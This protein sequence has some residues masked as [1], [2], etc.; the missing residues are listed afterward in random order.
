M[1]KKKTIIVDAQGKNIKGV[2]KDV[3]Q[4]R[5]ETEKLDKSRN[6]LNKTTDSYNRREKGAAQMGMNSTKSFSKMQQT[7]GDE[8]GGGAGGL[9]RAYALL[10][11][12]VF[13]LSA[14]FGILSRSAQVDT[15][16]ESMERL[17]VVT[18]NA[19]K[20]MARELQAAAS[21]GLDFA[22]AMRSTSLA[23]SA[24]FD[25]STI[26]ELG[27][28]AKNAAVSLGRP[29]ADSLDRIFRG[30]IKVE[31]ELLDEIGLFVRVKEASARYASSLGMAASELTEFQKRQAFATESVRQGQEKFEEFSD[32]DIDAFAL[33]AA[34]F[35]DLAHEA[36][37]FVNRGLGPII[38]LLAENKELLGAAF[39]AIAI[40]LL[41]K[42][43]PAMGLFTRSIADQ[44][45]T[46]T[47]A[48]TKYVNEIKTKAQLEKESLLESIALQ[49]QKTQKEIEGAQKARRLQD[50]ERGFKGG[51]KLTQAK[52]EIK[53][54]VSGQQRIN[55]LKQKQVALNASM[56]DSTRQAI[57]EEQAALEREIQM[58]IELLNIK[59]QQKQVSDTEIATGGKNKLAQLT[60]AKLARKEILAVG[61]ASVAATA[62]THGFWA[63]LKQINV[64]LGL[65][66]VAAKDAGIRL[67]IFARTLFAVRGAVVALTTAI[68]AL[69]TRIMG[70]LGWVLLLLPVITYFLKQLGFWS[71]EAKILGK[72][73]DEMNELIENFGEKMSH[74]ANVLRD[75]LSP[76]LKQQGAQLALSRTI[77][78]TTE[79]IM[80]QAQALEVYKNS[81]Q[82]IVL[83]WHDIRTDAGFGPEADKLRAEHEFFGGLIDTWETQTK[84]IQDIM[85][86]EGAMKN[87]VK[88]RKE[89]NVALREQIKAQKA[90]DDYTR[91]GERG[92]SIFTAVKAARGQGFKQMWIDANAAA[93]RYA[94]NVDR[95]EA[96][97]EKK[98]E[99]ARALGKKY[100]QD[101]VSLVRRLK[102]MLGIY[103]ELNDAATREAAGGENLLSIQ[104]GA[105]DALRE[106]ADQFLVKT[107]IDK[108]LATFAQATKNIMIDNDKIRVSEK[109]RAAF[110]KAIGEDNSAIFDLMSRQNQLAYEKT[111]EIENQA[112]REVAQM[113]ILQDQKEEYERQQKIMIQ[114]KTT[115]QSI[116]KIQKMMTKLI[117]EHSHFAAV[118][119]AMDKKKLELEI[120][121]AEM[122]HENFL[123]QKKTTV[124]DFKQGILAENRV[125]F[126]KEWLAL[127]NTRGEFLSAENSLNKI[128]LMRLQERINL[129]THGF[130]LQKAT[131][132][133]ALKRLQAQEKL[134]KANLKFVKMQMQLFSLNRRGSTSLT[135]AESIRDIMNAERTR[136][137]T[138]RENYDLQIKVIRAQF[139]ILKAEAEILKKRAQLYNV[140]NFSIADVTNDLDNAMSVQIRT[141]NAELANASMGFVLNLAKGLEGLDLLAGLEEGKAPARLRKSLL[142]IGGAAGILGG[143]GEGRKEIGEDMIE[144]QGYL[145]YYK[146]QKDTPE[147]RAFILEHEENLKR[148]REELAALDALEFKTKMDIMTASLLQFVDAVQELGP[149]G[150][151]AAALGQFSANL[152]QMGTVFATVFND[153]KATDIDKM[154]AGLQMVATVIAG[155]ASVLAA[156]ARAKT[157]A[158]DDQIKM[159]KKLDGKSEQS[160]AKIKAMEQKKEQIAKKQFD[161][162]KKLMI[163]Q[164]IIST[165]AG[166][167]A[168]LQVPLIGPALA[169]MI[170]ALGI[171]QIAII[172]KTSY[173]GGGDIA[174]ASNTE[175]QIGSRNNKV[176]VSRGATGGELSYLRGER[177]QGQGS[178]FT[179]TGGAA[180]LRKGYNTGGEILVGE[181][182]PEVIQ[183]RGGYEV[184][185]NDRL[186][187]GNANV[188]FTINAVDAAGVEDV[189]LRQRGNIIGMIRSAANDAG[190]GF[191]ETVDTDVVGYK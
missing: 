136:R 35:S 46:A 118:N 137:K 167:A 119:L 68:T 62:E 186:G 14:A 144:E 168:A 135:G 82:D 157:Q 25:S 96:E 45:R 83:L 6:K 185:P 29:I 140:E 1:A 149:E 71:K 10:A 160:L 132:E 9:V 172:K 108:P 42:A 66:G 85:G 61:M 24:G 164:A 169:A 72:A 181:Q 154:V 19:V 191:L 106:Y 28:V 86:N 78:D 64:E 183:A 189:L 59:K 122:H 47:A 39:G 56:R 30:V 57:L 102:L 17:E 175:L 38:E 151:V 180:G 138:A 130:Q 87:M 2:A 26:K 97:I 159:E 148:M 22:E 184:I 104:K 16:I 125:K 79:K 12:N 65:M 161:V 37:S 155:T 190:E 163:A 139:A 182:G 15:L 141:L 70:F 3:K 31:P 133:I 116:A 13:A 77:R 120:E 89:M 52:L 117:K 121:M 11:A 112:L 103:D 55:A 113:E 114:S 92:T 165:A 131:A 178:G 107:D 143:I 105:Q 69:M 173:Q 111:K 110:L 20:S 95:L 73:T 8:G 152:M 4:T 177:G 43:I 75:T 123:S 100:E 93:T 48:H 18:G 109:D 129:E 146:K 34:S 171:A 150:L 7:I 58:E 32:I 44:A 128:E 158:I 99:A 124:E 90:L 81:S 176:D 145:N 170:T 53:E 27:E 23:L 51:K 94:D 21:G 179:A 134:N 127:G 187:G 60:T 91:I 41:R 5:Q 67:T 74:N 142:G 88:Q 115:I 76:T 147:N 80:K 50:T 63:A 54:S 162:N 49:K 101:K 40:A 156:D 98:Q 36:L 166:A 84:K 174:A 126:M 33:L 153:K 188:N